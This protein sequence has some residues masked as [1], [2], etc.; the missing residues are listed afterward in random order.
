MEGFKG[1]FEYTIA[2][3]K[4]FEGVLKAS[5]QMFFLIITCIV[6]VTSFF[7]SIDKEVKLRG[8]LIKI[9]ALKSVLADI[10]LERCAVGIPT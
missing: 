2:S 8:E 7:G 4:T 6:F 5:N 1:S 9:K 3:W 10:G